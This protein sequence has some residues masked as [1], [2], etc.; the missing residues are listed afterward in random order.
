VRVDRSKFM[1]FALAISATTATVVG[2]ASPSGDEDLGDQTADAVTGG[3]CTATSIRK[4]GEGSMKPF[5]Y[6]E[7]FCFDLAVSTGAPDAE[8]VNYKFFDFV[9]EHCRMYSAQLQPAVAKKVQECLAK[10]NDARPRIQT[11][12]EDAATKEFDAMVMYNCGKDA[13]NSVCNEGIDQRVKGRCDRIAAAAAGEIPSLQI[14]TYKNK[15]MRIMSGLKVSA[16]DQMEACAKQ[17]FD[18]D[19]CIEGLEEDFGRTANV[20][21]TEGQAQEPL[22]APA[23]ECVSQL[24][25]APY[26]TA[27]RNEKL[28]YCKDMSERVADGTGITNTAYRKFLEAKCASYVTKF[29]R[30]AAD[31]AIGCLQ[32]AS[33]QPGG[34]GRVIYSCGTT[35]LKHI[36]RETSLDST[37]KGMVDE[38]GSASKKANAGGRLTRQCRTLLPG[39]NEAGVAKLKTCV[40]EQI[41]SLKTNAA[42]SASNGGDAQEYKDAFA[43]YAFYSCVEGL[44]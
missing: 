25:G 21:D 27:E 31:L 22:P 12:Y 39:I 1:S 37:C 19:S 2:C 34:T 4:P 16:R 6:Q 7:G 44:R 40:K 13:L 42:N 14:P 23:N 9:H 10:A 11:A 26:T 3:T 8:G 28:A 36:C 24:Y 43:P 18:L 17:G 33:E 29:D 35:A 15:C 32:D 41:A 5:A 38:I 30:P 20:A